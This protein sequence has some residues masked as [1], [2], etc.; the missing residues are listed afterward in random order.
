MLNFAMIHLC[1]FPDRDIATTDI[2]R[3]AH[4]ITVNPFVSIANTHTNVRTNYL[5]SRI[6]REI[7]LFAFSPTSTSTIY[8]AFAMT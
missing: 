5:S 3:A 7:S 6:S 2:K 1:V 8:S 4:R